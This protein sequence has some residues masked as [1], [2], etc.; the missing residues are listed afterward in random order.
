MVTEWAAT[1]PSGDRQ[2]P[3]RRFLSVRYRPPIDSAAYVWLDYAMLRCM[4]RRYYVLHS[5]DTESTAHHLLVE[6]EIGLAP[7]QN[8]GDVWKHRPQPILINRS[9]RRWGSISRLP[10]GPSSR[11]W[12]SPA[13]GWRLKAMSRGWPARLRRG[14][15]TPGAFGRS[16]SAWASMRPP[17]TR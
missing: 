6:L 5:S 13:R 3:Y 9:S 14:P 16:N 17:K 8:G 11:S 4:S 2:Q 15:N 10:C 7:Q 1:T 12:C